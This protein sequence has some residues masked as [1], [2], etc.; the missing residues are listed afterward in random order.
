MKKVDYDKKLQ[1]NIDITLK[2]FP[3]FKSLL[4]NNYPFHEKYKI[5]NDK[6]KKYNKF[7]NKEHWNNIN[8]PLFLN[9]YYFTKKQKLKNLFSSILNVLEWFSKTFKNHEGVKEVIKPLYLEA[10]DIEQPRFWSVISEICLSKLISNKKSFQ[11]KR[12]A[13]RKDKKD[14]HKGNYD[15]F[16]LYKNK[17]VNIDVKSVLL[18]KEINE[19]NFRKFVSTRSKQHI[20]KKFKNLPKNEYGIIALVFFA[21]TDHF[22]KIL[23]NIENLKPYYYEEDKIKSSHSY[24]LA[25]DIKTGKLCMFD[26]SYDIKFSNKLFERV[27]GVRRQNLPRY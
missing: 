11:I 1:N 20:D 10:W 6:M 8:L 7:R 14:K 9:N 26:D 22:K 21:K 27:N 12:F 3:N 15:I 13:K 25:C 19:E 5:T 24:I 23:E 4:P 18:T 2:N 17:P 16:V